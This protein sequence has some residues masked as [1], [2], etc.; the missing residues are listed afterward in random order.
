MAEA[1]VRGATGQASAGVYELGG[2]D[3]KTFRDWMHDMLAVV[4]RRRLVLNMPF[5]KARIVGG[6]LDTVQV[7]T[8][9][10]IENKML[11]RDQVR[12]LRKD[13]VVSDRAR[14]LADLGITPTPVAAV[15]PEYLWRFRPSG[16]YEAIKSSAKNLRK[17][18]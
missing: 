7:V 14:T 5:W 8:G 6:L 4:G 13:N 11:T 3:V 9:G 18:S 15:L 10:L 17:P 12:T 2:P 1:A 16:Q